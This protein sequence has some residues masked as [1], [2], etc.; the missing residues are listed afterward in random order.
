MKHL[1]ILLFFTLFALGSYAQKSK[2]K[3]LPDYDDHWLHFG[4]SLATNQATFVVTPVKDLSARDTVLT[5][6][7]SPKWG[8]NLSIVSDL[9]LHKYLTL[10]FLPALSFQ[11]RFLNYSLIVDNA[12]NP[13]TVTFEKSVEST[14]IEFP[15]NLKL[16]STRLNN[17]SAYMIGGMKYTI[18]LASQHDVKNSTS[19]KDVIIKLKKHDYAFEAGFGL[20]YYFP[21]FKFST[22]IKGVWG[23]RDLLIKENDSF[24]SSIDKLNSRLILI[25]LHFE[26]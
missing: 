6:I 1:H 11:D 14:T 5:I 8:F 12:G 23:I 20:D 22:E 26:G 24:S 25:S 15:F 19:P 4:F 3:N 17:V 7:P 16:R 10:R 18:D 2:V 13:D 21:Y 9:R